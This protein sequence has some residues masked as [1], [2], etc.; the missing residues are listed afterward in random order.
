MNDLSH[1][2]TSF[3]S[4]SISEA[5]VIAEME[6]NL[7]L[8]MTRSNTATAFESCQSAHSSVQSRSSSSQD[9]AGCKVMISLPGC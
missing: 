1:F 4:F 6:Q 8:C 7:L 5:P 9:C 2:V 3:G